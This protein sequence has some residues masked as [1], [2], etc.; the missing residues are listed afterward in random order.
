MLKRARWSAPGPPTLVGTMGMG[1]LGEE[2]PDGLAPAAKKCRGQ[3]G[4]G[5]KAHTSRR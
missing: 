4:R 3:K 1:A 5:S 2:G